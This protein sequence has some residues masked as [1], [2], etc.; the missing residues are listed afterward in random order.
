M[1]IPFPIPL[2]TALFL[3]GCASLVPSTIARLQGLDPINSDPNEIEVALIL[4]AGLTIPPGAAELKLGAVRGEEKLDASFRLKTTDAAV[5]G[6]DVPQG[7]SVSLLRVSPEDVP[8]MRRVQSE[9]AIWKKQDPSTQGQLSVGLG[10]CGVGNGPARD[11]RASV[12]IR[13]EAEG[14]L[15]PL[16]KDTSIR[17]LIGPELFDAIKPCGTAQ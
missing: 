5:S 11:S 14:A 13:T 3:A 8:R 7:A 1:S 9:I 2:V 16:V 12:L 6:L 4:P 17:D 15:L 10:A